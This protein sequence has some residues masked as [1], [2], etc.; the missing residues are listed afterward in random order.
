M[1]IYLASHGCCG[2]LKIL[3][4]AWIFSGSRI[5]TH[6]G[7]CIYRKAINIDK[8]LVLWRTAIQAESGV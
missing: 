1:Q 6:L 5:I 4:Q 3:K 7:L 8:P 2:C